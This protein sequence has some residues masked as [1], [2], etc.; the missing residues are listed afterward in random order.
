MEY[1]D[2]Y[3]H[4]V[5]GEP[6]V[7][8]IHTK[9]ELSCNILQHLA[10]WVY[11]YGY[12][13]FPPLWQKTETIDRFL[14]DLSVL[15][16][17]FSLLPFKKEDALLLRRRSLLKSALYNARI[18]GNTLSEQDMV[19][20]MRG[21]VREKREVQNLVAAYEYVDHHNPKF[22]SREMILR[23]HQ[24]I[25]DGVANEQGMFRREESAIFNAS[26]VAVYLTPVPSK[27]VQLMEDW[28][29][30][31]NTISDLYPL[32]A[33][34]SHIWFEKIH[35][36]LDG[37]GRVGRLVSYWIL[38]RGDY[39]FGGFVP[40]EKFL[41]EH[42]D[43]YYYGLSKDT[44]DV[45]IFVEFFLEALLS[46][47]HLSLEEAKNPKEEAVPNL[48]PRRMELMAIIRDHPMI[49]F[50]AIRRRFLA[51]PVRTLHYDLLTLMRC[52]HIKKIGSTRGALYTPS[53]SSFERT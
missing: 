47:A 25:A 41:D 13:K 26:G 10:T 5:C 33:A 20:P 36:F 28:Y 16:T 44:S 2:L 32:Q 17:A 53:H 38:K 49:S 45:T 31:T 43:Q 37:N 42:K 12:M 23:L 46:Q 21:R 8:G 22:L 1:I 50:D 14:Y 9:P 15:K 18:E 34:V 51:V 52:G 7:W 27:I 11:K 40:L 30:Y 3:T 4:L 29:R 24:M 6:G 19:Y 35:P 48:S 39:D